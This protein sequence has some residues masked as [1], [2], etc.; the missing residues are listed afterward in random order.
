MTV[1]QKVFL[2]FCLF[3]TWG[4]FAFDDPALRPAFISSIRDALVGLGVFAAT[5][6]NPKE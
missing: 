1:N 2:A 5:L 6:Q 4:I 3:L